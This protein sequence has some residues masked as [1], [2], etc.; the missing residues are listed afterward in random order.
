MVDA[1]VMEAVKFFQE[2]IREKGIRMHDLILFG[3]SG[4]GTASAGAMLISQ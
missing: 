4:T 1:E 3:S 2:K